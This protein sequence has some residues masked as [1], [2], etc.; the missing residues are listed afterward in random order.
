MRLCCKLENN[1]DFVTYNRLSLAAFYSCEVYCKYTQHLCVH[2]A[3]PLIC[4]AYIL[5]CVC[6]GCVAVR[7]CV[8]VLYIWY[9]HMHKCLAV[10]ALVYMASIIYLLNKSFEFDTLVSLQFSKII[11]SSNFIWC[12][13]VR[14]FV[15]MA[16]LIYTLPFGVIVKIFQLN[17][18]NWIVFFHIN[19]LTD[20]VIATRTRPLCYWMQLERGWDQGAGYYLVNYLA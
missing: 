2:N 16:V 18:R 17:I 3:V 5:D 4:N 10:Y 7:G 15:F 1:Q 11:V 9:R 19:A 6:C 8:G 14:V 13:C 12:L 20:T